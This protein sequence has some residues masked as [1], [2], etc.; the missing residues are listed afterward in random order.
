MCVEIGL[1]GSHHE[2]GCRP[3][4]VDV[5]EG[6]VVGREPCERARQPFCIGRGLRLDG[7][8]DPARAQTVAHRIDPEPCPEWLPPPRRRVKVD[9]GNA[10]DPGARLIPGGSAVCDHDGVVC[11]D[12]TWVAPSA[13]YVQ[14]A[15]AWKESEMA[16][17]P[18][19]PL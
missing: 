12:G 19:G 8:D 3:A 9:G 14:A 2:A 18:G 13:S 16:Q 7:L 11:C 17:D 6:R 10:Q 15:G 4:I 5:S 1:V